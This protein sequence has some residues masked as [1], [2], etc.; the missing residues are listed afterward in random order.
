MSLLHSSNNFALEGSLESENKMI[1]L[2]L[3]WGQWASCQ[4]VKVRAFEKAT[5]LLG[6]DSM[7]KRDPLPMPNSLLEACSWAGRMWIQWLV[8]PYEGDQIEHIHDFGKRMH[9]SA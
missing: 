1:I 9:L 6:W 2:V 3:L 5:S 8:V 4:K 7:H